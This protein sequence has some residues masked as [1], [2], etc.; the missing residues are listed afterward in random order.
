M[1]TGIKVQKNGSLTR[2]LPGKWLCSD[3][4]FCVQFFV[5]EGRHDKSMLSNAPAIG[6]ARELNIRIIIML[7]CFALPELS[8]I[9]LSSFAV[10]ISL[11]LCDIKHPCFNLVKGGILYFPSL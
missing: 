8:V 6:Y 9:F 3:A 5:R 10:L 7:L 1:F 4:Q 2:K 11:I